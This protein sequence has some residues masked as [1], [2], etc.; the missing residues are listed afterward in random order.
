MAHHYLP[1]VSPSFY[2]RRDVSVH[3]L[4]AR[5]SHER[6]RGRIRMSHI[7][8]QAHD[9]DPQ[10][11]KMN[12][13]SSIL[14]QCH[15]AYISTRYRRKRNLG[16]IHPI[17]IHKKLS[18]HRPSTVRSKTR[19]PRER[20]S[21]LFATYMESVKTFPQ[22]LDSL[23][24]YLNSLQ[25][26][27]VESTGTTS[28]HLSQQSAS[29]VDLEM[30]STVHE[31]SSRSDAMMLQIL[32]AIK[33]HATAQTEGI[34][35]ESSNFLAYMG[36]TVA[37][38]AV[39][40]WILSGTT[41]EEAVL[42]L[43][44]AMRSTYKA[45]ADLGPVPIFIFQKLLLRNDMN[46]E[47]LSIFIRQ[48]WLLL[49]PGDQIRSDARDAEQP[50]NRKPTQS[51]GLDA[52][53]TLVVRLLR[54]C[55]NVWPAACRSIAELWVEHARI[56]KDTSRFAFHYNRILQILS[57]PSNE[58]PF[59]SLRHRQRAQ[60][61]LLRKMTDSHQPIPISREGYR[62]VALVQLAHRKTDDER[63]WANLKALSWPPWKEDK[64]GIDAYIGTELG[65]SRATNVLHQE[66]ERGYGPLTW[67]RA[68]GI[69]AGR[70]TDTSPT[71]QTRT[72]VIPIATSSQ[73]RGKS[74]A[75]DGKTK[76]SKSDPTIVWVARIQATRTLQEAWMSFLACKD[77]GITMT[78]KLYQM[79]IEKAIYD[80]KRQKC[81]GANECAEV[82][83]DGPPQ[84]RPL[85]GDGKEVVESSVSHNQAISTREPLPTLDSLLE[86]MRCDGVR[87]S[88][89][90]LELLLSHAR[91]F[92]E[93]MG[94]LQA[95]PL[96]T[97]VKAVLVLEHGDNGKTMLPPDAAPLLR[98]IPRWLFATYINFL[99]EYSERSPASSSKTSPIPPWRHS[100]VASKIIDRDKEL[101]RRRLRHAFRLVETCKPFYR[102]PWNSLLMSLSKYTTT[103]VQRSSSPEQG[104]IKYNRACSLLGYL[105]S[106]GLGIDFT[107][108]GYLCTIVQNAIASAGHLL[109]HGRYRERNEALAVLKAEPDMLKN[110]FAR[111]VRPSTCQRVPARLSYYVAFPDSKAVV[112][113]LPRLLRVPHPVHLHLYIRCL[114][115]HGDH[116]GLIDFME[117]LSEF[118]DEIM[119]EAKDMANGMM[120]FRRCLMALRAFG[121]NESDEL[122][123]EAWQKYESALNSLREVIASKSDWGGWP[124]DEEVDAYVR[125]GDDCGSP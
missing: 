62:A 15:T 115:Q 77:Q 109:E 8:A 28:T 54:H 22:P 114:G 65:I 49:T 121:Y 75:L 48:A 19:I 40:T 12:N 74:S 124:T 123:A 116:D 3:D 76:A 118:V 45:V 31:S 52:I 111:L 91:S 26:N 97:A 55:R 100:A 80:E 70:D 18:N 46:A 122:V 107:A 32:E 24:A 98:T 21:T 23:Q 103:I 6:K 89:R 66:A 38:F 17:A 71:I 63:T 83:T 50:S 30:H 73:V 82:F 120:M 64:L 81:A 87:P 110:R 10:R 36:Y 44:F 61:V 125:K 41:A 95:S 92:D 79:I 119:E 113:A 72:S 16:R 60:F 106:I 105:D 33:Q 57:L 112:P 43:Q 51:I 85:P 11:P 27:E 39:W 93:G 34:T 47:A 59:Q 29:F 99:C 5:D 88:G 35:T 4:F 56:H 20:L 14:A 53:T 68:A 13:L 86:Q 2:T 25:V 1:N 37:D 9:L 78:P 101:I 90:L 104:V 69:L 84:Q 58:S 42:R 96:S 117:W 102:P 67:E 94:I 7:A 108:F